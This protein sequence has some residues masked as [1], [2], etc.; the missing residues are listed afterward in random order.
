MKSD[1]VELDL[2]SSAEVRRNG[3]GFRRMSMSAADESA[4]PS[5]AAPHLVDEAF[6]LFAGDET[7]A[8]PVADGRAGD[9]LPSA[10]CEALWGRD[11]SGDNMSHSQLS[12]AALRIQ[13]QR[14]LV[15]NLSAQLAALDRQREHLAQLLQDIDA[16][17]LVGRADS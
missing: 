6:A 15:D 9:D 17:R 2:P 8:G 13:R 11:A 10:A 12:T 7:V 14:R 4:G 16:G 1:P 5:E 3:A